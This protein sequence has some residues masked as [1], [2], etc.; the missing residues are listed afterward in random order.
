[1][2][3]KSLKLRALY[4]IEDNH[5]FAPSSV[6]AVLT[7]P[8]PLKHKSRRNYNPLRYS[9]MADHSK[10]STVI[11]GATTDRI[12]MLGLYLATSFAVLP[13]FVHYGLHN[14]FRICSS[15]SFSTKHHAIGAIKNYIS[16][17]SF[18][19]TRVCKNYSCSFC[20]MQ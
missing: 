5:N 10:E 3:Q 12:G 17:C 8:Y 1:M 19:T 2:K 20:R 14:N 6:V 15:N 18:C 4:S 16:N 7:Q 9:S 13:P 11:S